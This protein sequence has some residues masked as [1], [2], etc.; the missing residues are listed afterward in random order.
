M[1]FTDVA[2]V[3]SASGDY[4]THTRGTRYTQV[5]WIRTERLCARKRPRRASCASEV[6]RAREAKPRKD[7][8]I[9]GWKNRKRTLLFFS[10]FPCQNFISLPSLRRSPRFLP[11]LYDLSS[12]LPRF[13][14]FIRLEE[15]RCER[16]SILHA[17]RSYSPFASLNLFLPL[18]GIVPF[19]RRSTHR[20]HHASPHD[21]SAF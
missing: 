3:A 16:V 7:Q 2:L 10:Q 11:F 13:R 21:A 8:R 19:R 1:R 6:C 12:Q 5:T 18:P 17:L 14:R 20:A 15:F 9:N 4:A